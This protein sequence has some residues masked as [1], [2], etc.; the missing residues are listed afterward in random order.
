M[1]A[2]ALSEVYSIINI[3]NPKV[4]KK[5]PSNFYH[6]IQIN[7]DPLYNPKFKELPQNFENLEHDTKIILALIYKK[8]FYEDV[9]NIN[10]I[11]EKNYLKN[12]IEIEKN[13]ENSKSLV[14]YKK[15][16]IEKIKDFFKKLKKKSL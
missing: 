9:N 15:S 14:V 2:R 13:D 4:I 7:R 1:N 12:K 10:E 3:M 16:L 11:E 5:I 6:F 8:Y